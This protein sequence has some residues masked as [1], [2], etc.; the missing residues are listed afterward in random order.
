LRALRAIAANR[1]AIAVPPGTADAIGWLEYALQGHWNGTS[2]LSVLAQSD[3]GPVPVASGYDP[4]IDIV[5]A[6]VYGAIPCTDTRLLATAGQIRWQ[7]ADSASPTVY[8]VNVSDQAHG[9]G[10]LM[11]RYPGDTYD[12]DVSHPV[13]GGHPWA[14]CTANFAELY[15]RLAREIAR[16]QS[17]PYDE[18]S[19]Q[20]LGQVGI[21]A[22]TTPAQAVTF[23][24][25][26]A[27]AMLQAVVYHSDDLEL[28]EQ[29]DGTSGYEKSVTDLAWSYAAFL[30][31]VRA[32]TARNIEG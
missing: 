25:G 32:K 24:E 23:L 7:W 27:D 16:T 8:P 30:S 11:G 21:G 14:L 12:G 20:F 6:C 1:H 5:M 28:S 29:F 13:P 15:Y 19:S 2:Y 3:T 17:V 10:P 18:L 4:N 22:N 31:A 9:L 26:A